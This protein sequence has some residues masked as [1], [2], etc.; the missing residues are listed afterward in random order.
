MV[1][2]IDTEMKSFCVINICVTFC[3]TAVCTAG[4]LLGET[5]TGICDPTS[6]NQT[7]T[8][9]VHPKNIPNPS[10]TADCLQ[11]AYNFYE[12]S[13]NRYC[14]E[15][16]VHRK[17]DSKCNGDYQQ[18]LIGNLGLNANEALACCESYEIQVSGCGVGRSEWVDVES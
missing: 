17:N 12:Y 14:T 10:G 5:E 18:M 3:L 16:A 13:V 11:V 8:N 6:I 1:K 15:A 7:F 4:L 9:K 2:H